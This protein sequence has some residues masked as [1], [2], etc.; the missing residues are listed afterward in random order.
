MKKVIS[1]SIAVGMVIIMIIS[2]FV[3]LVVFAD[4]TCKITLSIEFFTLGNGYLVEPITL[5]VDKNSNVAEIVIDTLHKNGYLGFY[6]GATE[7]SF[8]LAYIS[9]GDKKNKKYEG[10]NSSN[11][12]QPLENSKIINISEAVPECIKEH[13]NQDFPMYE[14]SNNGFIGEF[15]FTSGSGWM[16]SVNNIFPSIAMSEYDINNG[17]IIRL[18]FTLALGRDIGGSNVVN[19]ELPYYNTANKDKLTELVAQVNGNNLKNNNIVNGPYKNALDVLQKVN[20]AQSD[21]D[22]AY[23]ILNNAI[24]DLNNISSSK[25]ASVVSNISSER[26]SSSNLSSINTSM[27]TSN[28]S[29]SGSSSLVSNNSS[30][31]TSSTLTSRINN[32]ESSSNEESQTISEIENS[33]ISSIENNSQDNSLVISEVS[34]NVDVSKNNESSNFNMVSSNSVHSDNIQNGSNSNNT[35]RII[36]ISFGIL[37]IVT[38]IGFI[39]YLILKKEHK[40]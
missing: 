27:T 22:N 16:Y 21:V 8:Y 31:I 26:N 18:Q 30:N 29:S 15:D 32:N 3:F 40:K 34:S 4:N 13:L 2:S 17:D 14:Y 7:E 12:G 37:L 5:E 38:I 6:D 39:I 33:D 10:Y 24:K 19:G 28:I 9:S 25:P 11:S 20:A 1:S 35:L 23:D 36:L